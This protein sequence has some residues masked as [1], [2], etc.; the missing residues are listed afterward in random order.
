MSGQVIETIVWV[1]C[2]IG[3]GMQFWFGVAVVGIP[4]NHDVVFRDKS[5]VKYWL[6]MLTESLIGA[7]IAWFRINAGMN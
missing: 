1:I 6:V 5:P 3:L 7:I 2:V 4:A